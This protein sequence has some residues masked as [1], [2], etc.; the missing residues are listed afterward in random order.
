MLLGMKRD[1]WKDGQLES[2]E[3]TFLNDGIVPSAIMVQFVFD[4]VGIFDL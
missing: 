4:L 1:D 2:Q 3:A